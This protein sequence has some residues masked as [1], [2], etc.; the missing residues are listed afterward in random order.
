M[1]LDIRLWSKLTKGLLAR[2][3]DLATQEKTAVEDH[4]RKLRQNRADDKTEHHSRF[5][6]LVNDQ[7][8]FKHEKSVHQGSLIV[9]R[10]L[11][12]L[13]AD[14]SKARASQVIFADAK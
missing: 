1:Y 11:F 3:M 8:I 2:D 7:W 4:Q 9:C 10:E 6:S 12:D 14:E 5:F 13:S